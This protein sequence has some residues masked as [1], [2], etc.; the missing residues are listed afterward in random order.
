MS[1]FRRFISIH[2]SCS[3]A[4]ASPYTAASPSQPHVWI[5]LAA[6]WANWQKQN[7]KLLINIT[8]NAPSVLGNSWDNINMPVNISFIYSP[9]NLDFIDS[10]HK[11]I[12]LLPLIHL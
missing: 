11:Y 1:V 5:V 4:G 2:V 6:T 10:T 9:F 3:E 8:G 12:P 7:E